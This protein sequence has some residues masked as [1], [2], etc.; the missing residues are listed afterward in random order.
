MADTARDERRPR[1]YWAS[2]PDRNN[3]TYFADEVRA[4]RLR[5]GWGYADELSLDVIRGIWAANSGNWWSHLSTAQ[6]E[7]W[8]NYPFHPGFGRDTIRAGD[9]VLM[10]N[11]PSWGRFSLMEALDDVYHYDTTGADYRHWRAVRLLTPAGIPNGHPDVDAAIRTTLKCRSR[12]WRLDHVG[13]GITK[14]LALLED[15]AL[16]AS[17]RVTPEERYLHIERAARKAAVDPARRAAREQIDALIDQSF[18][19]AELEGPVRQILTKAFPGAEVEQV[20]GTAEAAHGTDILVRLPN[21]LKP[22]EPFLIPVQ[23]K[24]HIGQSDAGVGQLRLAASYW[25]R[26]GTVIALALVNT[27][28]LGDGAKAALDQLSADTGLSYYHLNRDQLIELFVDAVL[29]D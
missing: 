5:Q 2:R 10:P 15:G 20:G 12:I 14:L 16:D 19:S 26:E 21:P 27:G 17:Q 7:A 18:Q 11:I 29:G 13:K 1:R 8:P 28:L 24:N 22:E 25:K 9:I 6:R 23:V 3:P 4:G